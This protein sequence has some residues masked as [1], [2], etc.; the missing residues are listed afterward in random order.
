MHHPPHYQKKKIIGATSIFFVAMLG[1]TTLLSMYHKTWQYILMGCWVPWGV[2][3]S[4]RQLYAL[5]LLPFIFS[6]PCF[7]SFL[8]FLITRSVCPDQFTRITTNFW[9]HWISRKSSKHVRHRGGDRH[10]QRRS[11]PGIEKRNKSLFLLAHDLKCF[12]FLFFSFRWC[13]VLRGGTDEQQILDAHGTNPVGR[14]VYM[15]YIF[16]KSRQSK[17][18]WKKIW[19]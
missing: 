12:S 4:N 1:I 18:S 14:L 6:L 10:I 8:F 16:K 17:I 11:N 13:W 7:F 3:I 19:L 15:Q 5:D 9:A 2:G